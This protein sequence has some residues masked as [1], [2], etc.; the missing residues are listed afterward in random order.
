MFTVMIWMRDIFKDCPCQVLLEECGISANPRISTS[1]ELYD[2]IKSTL[3]NYYPHWPP[4]G[5]ICEST[6]SYL[7]RPGNQAFTMT[8]TISALSLLLHHSSLVGSIGHPI[9]LLVLRIFARSFWKSKGFA[10]CFHNFCGSSW[11]REDDHPA[12]HCHEP[13]TAASGA[14]SLTCCTFWNLKTS[15]Y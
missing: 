3:Q 13:G 5:P 14:M 2:V 12:R 9:L 15:T 10:G 11:F 7:S 1:G 6:G 4:L 8:L